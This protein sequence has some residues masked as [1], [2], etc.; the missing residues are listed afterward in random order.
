MSNLFK[1]DKAKSEKQFIIIGT[2]E[3]GRGPGAGPVYSAAVCFPTINTKLI[4][5]FEKLN[6]SKQLNEKIREELFELIKENSIFSIV[7]S[8]VEE[9]ENLNILQASLLSMKKACN[10]VIEQ[11][12]N[13]N[14][15]KILVDGNK[16]IPRT[17][18]NQEFIIKGDSKSAS[19][20]AA[21]IL[22]KVS[23]DKF[24]K[25]LAKEFPHYGWESNKGYLTKLHLDAIDKFGIT[26][27]HRKKFL[28]KHFE[29]SKQMSLT[30][31]E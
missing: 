19:I 25:E 15:I 18:W 23:R 13:N 31:W 8:S 2:D 24:M 11:I 17:N 28:E 9:I 20:A 29:K 26:K 21:S 14:L 22:A 30:L 7:S 3:A 1:F 12:E 5:L 10:T 16:L 27:W 6:D 4:K